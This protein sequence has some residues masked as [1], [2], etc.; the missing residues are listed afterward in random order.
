MATYGFDDLELEIDASVGGS[1]TSLKAY[2][3]EVSGFEVEAILEDGHT[4]G[5]TWVERVFTGLKDAKE[6][7]LKGF[8]DDTASTGPNAMLVGIGDVRSF[9]FTWGG[10]KT[11]AFEALIGKYSRLPAKGELTKFEAT[12]VPTGAVT[13]A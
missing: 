4:A 6:F 12:I 7:T 9:R 11:S 10:S 3:T 13:E 8:Y 1:L 2:V 5:D